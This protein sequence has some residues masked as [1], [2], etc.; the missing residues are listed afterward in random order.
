[1]N[2]PV[3]VSYADGVQG[4]SFD[5]GIVRIDLYQR[6]PEPGG[7]TDDVGSADRTEAHSRLVMPIEGFLDAYAKMSNLMAKL[8]DANVVERRAEKNELADAQSPNFQ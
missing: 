2:I 6:V 1:M 8:E 7:A 5:S 3:Q 4:L